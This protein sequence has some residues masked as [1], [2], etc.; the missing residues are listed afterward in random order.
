[1]VAMKK[2]SLCMTPVLQEYDKLRGDPSC[3]VE[4]WDV[5]V[6][7]TSDAA[8]QSVYEL[9]ISD[10]LEHK[11]LPMRTKYH[12]I[13][14]PPGC[15]IGS[16]GSTMYTISC[17]A[18]LEPNWRKQ[19]ILL[20]HAGG[21]S[22]RLPSASVL[23]KAFITIPIGNR[24][25]SMFDIKL[26]LCMPFAKRLPPGLFICC[27]DTFESFT[28]GNNGD[29]NFGDREGFLALAHPSPLYV[30]KGH[31][32]YVLDHRNNKL[33]TEVLNC[34]KVLQKPTEQLMKEEGAIICPSEVPDSIRESVATEQDWVFTDSQFFFDHTISEKLLDFYETHKPLT[35]EICAY[36]DFLQPLGKFADAQYVTNCKNIMSMSDTVISTR[37]DLYNL[38]KGSPLGVVALKYSKFYHI[39]T[40]IEYLDNF[41]SNHDLRQ[42]L[43]LSRFC[44]SACLS[45]G[46]SVLASCEAETGYVI[47]SLV[48][49]R[50]SFSGK[51]IVEYCTFTGPSQLRVEENCVISDCEY[52]SNSDITIPSN[53]FIQTVPVLDPQGGPMYVTLMFSIYEDMKAK[54]SS[55]SELADLSYFG[56]GLLSV[57]PFKNHTQL[58]G[59]G[60]PFSLWHAK[61]FPLSSSAQESFTSALNTL[62]SA[63]S[64][65]KRPLEH[66]ACSENL[67]A[68][69][70]EAASCAS[71][72]GTIPNGALT[73]GMIA[74]GVQS[75]ATDSAA[76]NGSSTNGFTANGHSPIYYSFA[77]VIS[78]KDVKQMI[79]RRN[80]LSEQ[81]QNILAT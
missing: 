46:S 61:L 18:K 45:A 69:N 47:N 42:E 11:Q 75:A 72:N 27:P 31:G 49:D 79:R 60:N 80:I 12:V 67:L 65:S 76:I 21:S 15:K 6:L 7:T 2:T 78:Y 43:G 28:F 8:Q 23:G 52:T 63:L 1:M 40:M 4:F 10:K 5:V 13:H 58:F 74:N 68:H 59:K 20:M 44:Y 9:E 51:S 14:D 30:G 36:G 16:G 57:A 26:A 56:H 62:K 55:V 3:C 41:C 54:V 50:C 64:H 19:K 29:W 39:G 32:V 71:A 48:T 37:R 35:A 25:Y 81:I 22:Q 53:T 77:D 17:L 24:L 73:N 70:G 38:L 66:S 33:D 34:K